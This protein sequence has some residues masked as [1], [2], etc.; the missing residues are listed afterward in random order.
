MLETIFSRSVKLISKNIRVNTQ[1]ILFKRNLPIFFVNHVLKSMRN[2]LISTRGKNMRTS[3]VQIL[4]QI[5]TESYSIHPGAN[6]NTLEIL[7]QFN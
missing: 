4:F 2:S 5:V 6:N 3:R 7:A 1:M